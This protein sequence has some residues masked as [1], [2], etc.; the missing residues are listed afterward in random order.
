MIVNSKGD[1]WGVTYDKLGVLAL[2]GVK[3][4]KA[5]NDNLVS[6]TTTLRAQLKAANDNHSAEIDALRNKLRSFKAAVAK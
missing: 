3:E 5:E 1:T 6:E 2:Q 4:L